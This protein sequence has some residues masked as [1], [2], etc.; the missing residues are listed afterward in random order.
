MVKSQ[1]E[2]TVH[3]DF[4]A[5][6]YRPHEEAFSTPLLFEPGEG[7][8]YGA[9]LDWTSL[10]V[11]RLTNQTLGKYIQENIFNPPGMTSSLHDPQNHPYISSRI[12][13]M[14]RREGDTLLPA[15]YPLR[16][17]VS[18]VSDLGTLL[19]DL[20]S[21][22]SKLLK[23]ESLDLVFAPQFAPSSSALSYIRH[24]TENYAAPAGI[25]IS[26]TEAPV[27]H[28]LA[29]LVVEEELSLSH[30]PA[31]TVT[32]NGMPNVIWAVNREKSLGMIFAT[33]LLPV[34]DENTVDLAMAF[35]RGAWDTFG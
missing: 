32:W 11:S 12:L 1:R 28:S 21:P 22:S 31:G 29:A 33:Q 16:E 6:D 4:Q 14:V 17:L 34:D 26:Q 13:Q 8:V 9:S 24:D 23:Q 25:P 35:M 5:K 10:L 18:S 3:M 27:N 7:W 15:N 20:M 19:S 30:M 2:I